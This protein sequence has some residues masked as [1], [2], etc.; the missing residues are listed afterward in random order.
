MTGTVWI[1]NVYECVHSS[2]QML[3]LKKKRFN[4]FL[5]TE[6]MCLL[7]NLSQWDH[8]PAGREDKRWKPALHLRSWKAKIDTPTHILVNKPE[9]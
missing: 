8:S 9:C 6:Y 1:K 7:I 3:P 4:G 5:A 2:T